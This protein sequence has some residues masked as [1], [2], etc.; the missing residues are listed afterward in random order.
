MIRTLVFSPHS[1]SGSENNSCR[2]Y[3]YLFCGRKIAIFI[4]ED[5]HALLDLLACLADLPEL[6]ATLSVGKEP[7]SANPTKSNTLSILSKI[8]RERI[9]KSHAQLE[10]AVKAQLE[11][12]PTWGKS[13]EEQ[14]LSAP[15]AE[16][17]DVFG[18]IV[19]QCYNSNRE[20]LGKGRGRRDKSEMCADTELSISEKIT[21][22]PRVD[23]EQAQVPPEV[24][25]PEDCELYIS[26]IDHLAIDPDVGFVNIDQEPDLTDTLPRN[27][28]KPNQQYTCKVKNCIVTFLSHTFQING[29][30][31]TTCNVT[32]TVFSAVNWL[33]MLGILKGRYS[34]QRNV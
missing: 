8:S 22:V 11:R 29:H 3:N 16:R 26:D 13:W 9:A 4:N 25:E 17:A 14:S 31:T 20:G 32:E 28:S 6:N 24:F 21:K 19:R 7:L 18:A 30:S 15:K 33:L 5:I 27:P 1:L 23:P 2:S 10:N 34:T 12:D